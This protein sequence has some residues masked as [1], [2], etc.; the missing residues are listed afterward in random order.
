ME[1]FTRAIE[2]SI[3]SENWYAA[4]TLAL[5]IPDICGRLSIVH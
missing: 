4:L 5:T 3:K 1:R 2:K